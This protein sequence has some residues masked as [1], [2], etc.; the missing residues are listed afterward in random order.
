M[1]WAPGS[2][3]SSSAPT[4]TSTWRSRRSAAGALDF[5]TK[6]YREQQLL[7]SINEALAQDA[8]A[9]AA[10]VPA[11]GFAARLATLSPRERQVTDLV[12]AGQSSKAIARVLRISH[13]TVEQHRGHVLA[14]LGLQSVADLVRLMVE[15]RRA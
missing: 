2:R 3:S 12:V 6:P 14:K 9:H 13:R 11:N 4:P 7:D 15:N 8:A 10:P 1:R 5:V